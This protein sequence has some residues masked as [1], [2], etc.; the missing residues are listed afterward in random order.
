MV[1]LEGAHLD[2]LDRLDHEVR[3]IILRD[4]V[5]EDRAEAEMPGPA[6]SRQILFMARFYSKTTPT[7]DRLLARKIH[8]KLPPNPDS[9]L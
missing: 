6:H 5:P 2:A 3:Q 1:H 4:P 7:S 8:E 9:A